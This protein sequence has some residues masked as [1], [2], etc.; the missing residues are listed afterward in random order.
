[1]S[2][3]NRKVTEKISTTLPEIIPAGYGYICIVLNDSSRDVITNLT[4]S[5]LHDILC[6]TLGTAPSPHSLN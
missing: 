1:M 3:I 5:S 6:K 4:P 2:K